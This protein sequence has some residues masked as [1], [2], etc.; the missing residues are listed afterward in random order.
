MQ[1]SASGARIPPVSSHALA[2]LRFGAL[3]VKFAKKT[4]K[5]EGNIH[6]LGRLIR[7]EKRQVA[8]AAKLPRVAFLT[9]HCLRE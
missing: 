4:N 6:A 9:L 1:R 2:I 7:R 3:A 8:R 5:I